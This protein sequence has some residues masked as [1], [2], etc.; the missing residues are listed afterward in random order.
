MEVKKLNRKIFMIATVFL[1]VAILAT[2]L[3]VAKPWDEKNNEK[4]QT[5]TT[6]FTPNVGNIIAAI[7]NPEYIPSED[8]PNKIIY[9]W[10]EEP[11]VAYAINVGSNTYTLGTDFEYTGVAVLTQIGAPFTPNPA[12]FDILVGSK[13]T[14]FRVDY[15]YDFGDGDGGLDGSIQMLAITAED[16]VMHIRSLRGTGDLQNVQIQA[17]SLGGFTHTGI[18]SGWP[19]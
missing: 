2:P 3:A 8:N 1:V 19:E 16:G 10:V 7:G 5:F 4:F 13:Q 6:S 12:L 9:S 11:M 15:M 17:T 14:K 18:V